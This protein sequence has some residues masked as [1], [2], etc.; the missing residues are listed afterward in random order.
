MRNWKTSKFSEEKFEISL[1]NRFL[2]PK[3]KLVN[4]KSYQTKEMKELKDLL[5]VYLDCGR[6]CHNIYYFLTVKLYS[7]KCEW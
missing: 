1:L 6:K 5:D 4:L 2:K 3:N 7:S